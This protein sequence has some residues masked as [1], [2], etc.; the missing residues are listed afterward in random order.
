MKKVIILGAGPAGVACAIQLTRFGIE[1]VIFEKNKIGGLVENANLIENYLGFPNGITGVEYVKLVKKQFEQYKITF[2][3]DEAIEVKLNNGSYEVS[4]AKSGIYSS[5]YLVVATGTEPKEVDFPDEVKEKVFYE[6]KHLHEVK[7]KSVVIIGAGDAA[8]DYALNL[9]KKN[10]VKIFNRSSTLK[11]LPLL[12]DR[13]NENKNIEYYE[14][15]AVK[16]IYLDN[17]KLKLLF[18]DDFEV[19]TDYL[20][21]A[22]GRLPDDRLL[23]KELKD[24]QNL[25]I[26]G[27]VKN[28]LLRQTT[29][30]AADGL[31]AATEIHER[32]TRNR[33]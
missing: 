17:N 32:I 2:I 29:I 12:V 11:A 23:T 3:N 9:S 14:N 18:N 27:D 33:A 6:I 22:I 10:Q 31:K 25:Y 15:S 26:V 19:L 7:N 16:K 5:E 24:T 1:T 8:F 30:A 20:I 4:S 28:G 21:F 13:V